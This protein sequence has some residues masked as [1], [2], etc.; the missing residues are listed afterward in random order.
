MAYSTIGR[1]TSRYGEY[2]IFSG[3]SIRCASHSS[4][5][6]LPLTPSM[7]TNTASRT[8]GRVALA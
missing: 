4:S 6:L 3:T 8:L 7:S 1:I 2:S 5:S